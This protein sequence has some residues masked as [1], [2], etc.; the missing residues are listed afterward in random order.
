MLHL[1]IIRTKI[2]SQTIQR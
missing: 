2:S 1:T